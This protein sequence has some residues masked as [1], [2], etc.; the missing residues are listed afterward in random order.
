MRVGLGLLLGLLIVLRAQADEVT[1]KVR[2]IYYQAAGGVLMEAS[3]LRR[4]GGVRWAD[5]ELDDRS[6]ALVQLPSGMAAGVGDVVAL[7]LATP[8]SI[9]AAEPLRVSRVSAIKRQE[10]QLASPAQ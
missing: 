2:A 3:L 5:V 9:A 8:K 1:G 10:T 7:Q 4:P 6:R